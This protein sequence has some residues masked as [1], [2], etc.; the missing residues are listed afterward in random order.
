MRLKDAWAVAVAAQK[1]GRFVETI[2]HCG[3]LVDDDEY[4]V[5]VHDATGGVEEVRDAPAA[6]RK[7]T[8][9]E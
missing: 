9:D 3:T 2:K 4:F 8:R 5:R 7:P 6:P 1:A